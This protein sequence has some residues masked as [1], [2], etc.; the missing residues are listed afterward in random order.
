MSD[1]DLMEELD[2]RGLLADCTDEPALRDR[3]SAGPTRFYVGFDP[4]AASLHVGSLIPLTVARLV[5]RHGH[6]PVLLLGGATGMIGDPSGRSDERN[7]LDDA[8]LDRNLE[9]LRAQ[10]QWLLREAGQDVAV[11]DNREWLGRM[12]AMELLRDVGRHFPINAMLARDSVKLRRDSESGMSFTEFSYQLLQAFDFWWLRRHLGVEVQVGG[13]D[14]WGNITAGIDFMRRRDGSVGW[15]LVWPLLS[16]ADGTKFGKSAGGNVWL[17]SALTSPFAFWQFWF[18]TDDR[19]VE[20]HLLRFS[21]RSVTELR[22][23]MAEHRAHPERRLAQR[24]LANDVTEWV[25]GEEVASSAEAA[26]R[27][28]FGRSGPLSDRALDLLEQ[29]VGGIRRSRDQLV[30]T[31]LVEMAVE[32]GL[33]SSLADA[34]RL[35]AGGGLRIGEEQADPARCLGAEDLGPQGWTLLRRGRKE[36]LLVRAV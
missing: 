3:L 24:A 33:C 28:L 23:V 31:P 26:A 35:A 6:E 34:R 9:G 8:T 11:V 22:A 20:Q 7:M 36:W 10:L 32:G 14:Q 17:D 27:I 29:E 19:D 5:A 18:N 1:G 21:V 2:E 16:K 4:T 12:S 25:H 13:S 15:G 30:G